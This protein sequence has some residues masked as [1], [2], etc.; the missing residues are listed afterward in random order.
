M[1][2]RA[3]RAGARDPRGADHV[4]RPPRRPEQDVAADHRGGAG[5]RGPAPRRGAARPPAA[6]ARRTMT[7]PGGPPPDA[8]ARA[9]S[10]AADGAGPVARHAR[11]PRRAAAPG[12]G[13]G[14]ADRRLPRRPA[15][16]LRRRTRS[17]ASRSPS[18]CAATSTTRRRAYANLDVV[19]RR[20][21][22]PTHL[23]RSAALTVDP[24]LLRGASL[25]AAWR[26]DRGGAAGRG[27]PH[28]RRGAAAARVGAAHRRRRCSTWRRGSCRRPSA[29]TAAARFG[30]RLRGRLLRD[31]A[32]VIVAG[33]EATDRGPAPAPH[34]R[35][36]GSGWS[37]SRRGP[38]SPRRPGAAAADRSAAGDADARAERERLGLPG[39]YLVYPG[40]YDARQDLATLL[41]ALA[42][43]A[44][45]GR[46]AD[47]RR[48]RRRGR[49]GSSSL[50]ASPDDRAALA[51]G[52]RA[53]RASASALAYAPRLARRRR[54]ALVRGARAAI[55]P[56]VS[57]AP[58]WP[59]IEA[60][61]CGTP[62]V[63]S[64][65]G[66]LPGDRR[67]R[68]DPRRAARPGPAGI[69]AARGLGRRPRPRRL[70]AAAQ[71]RAPSGRR[72]WADVAARDAGGLRRG[73]APA[74]LTTGRRRPGRPGQ[75][76]RTA[77]WRSATGRRR[78]GP[79]RP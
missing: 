54:P 36:T 44:D 31:A 1:T 20:L 3:D 21:L 37:R 58:G 77:R 59:A 42:S 66:A 53:S 55:L 11:R 35:A 6:A 29:R 39:R 63:A 74:R 14:A 8:W 73:R 28:R 12:A 43:L 72:T 41:R 56:V 51:R 46:P 22:P 65:V 16:R 45:A 70:A 40:R 76:V 2:F 30:Q 47:L 34:P 7:V 25:G 69:G 61:A 50:G 26:A 4:P 60:I 10:G 48:R 49:R 19:G 38:P 24:F 13:P 71:R 27:L 17:T 75:A 15:R 64:A 62:V 52:G 5:R 79:C 67:C 23:L 78:P 57:E 9:R 68:R 32:A 33:P 18:C